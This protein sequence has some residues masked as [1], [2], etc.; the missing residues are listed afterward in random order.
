M[1]EEI[2]TLLYFQAYL[3][4]CKIFG[5]QTNKY[6]SSTTHAHFEKPRGFLE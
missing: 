6:K 4:V 5:G 2:S 3:S 1:S